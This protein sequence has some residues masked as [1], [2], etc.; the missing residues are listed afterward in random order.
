MYNKAW[1][2]NWDKRSEV[3]IIMNARSVC[4]RCKKDMH[5][6][7][8]LW[9][10]SRKHTD[11]HRSPVC[12]YSTSKQ[13]LLQRSVAWRERVRDHEHHRQYRWGVSLFAHAWLD[14]SSLGATKGMKVGRVSF[15]HLCQNT[16]PA[17]AVLAQ[18]FIVNENRSFAFSGH[19]Y[20]S[21]RV[22]KYQTELK[23]SA[24]K[25]EDV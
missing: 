19:E 17:L 20:V 13:K 7:S 14:L 9:W 11:P 18:G 21:V 23:R 12:I 6:L 22:R 25:S 1:N 10:E 8:V 5:C 4:T 3:G 24:V 15:L 16:L 2:C